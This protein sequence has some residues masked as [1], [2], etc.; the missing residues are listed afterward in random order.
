MT[1]SQEPTP[2]RLCVL[3]GDPSWIHEARYLDDQ[4]LMSLAEAATAQKDAGT[5][6]AAP[7]QAAAATIR[8]LAEAMPQETCESE[9]AAAPPGVR[10][11][12]MNLPAW[13][14][15]A[16]SDRYLLGLPRPW[17]LRTLAE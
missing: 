2:D 14:T 3:P 10:L 4:L 9:S 1:T 6:P 16:L 15:E 11:Y 17:R 13:E 5:L 8:R 7:Y 12:V